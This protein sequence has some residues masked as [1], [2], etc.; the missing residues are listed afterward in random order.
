MT[1]NELKDFVVMNF[2]E[3]FKS[4]REKLYFK[5]SEEQNLTEFIDLLYISLATPDEEQKYEEQKTLNP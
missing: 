1:D 4:I 2:G 3:Y 5:L